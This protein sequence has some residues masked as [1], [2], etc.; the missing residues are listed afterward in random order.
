MIIHH[1]LG[2]P[3]NKLL[4]QIL[5]EAQAPP[6]TVALAG[7]LNCPLC[8]RFTRIEPARPATVTHAKKFNETL[9]IDMAYHDLPEVCQALV[10]HFIDEASWFHITDLVRE[11]VI[12]N[13]SKDQRSVLGNVNQITLLQ[14]HHNSW[15]R[16][17]GHSTCM[18]VDAD[19][20][21]NSESFKDYIGNHHTVLYP[22]AGEAHWQIG[23][24]ERHIQ[25]HKRTH[26]KLMLEEHFSPMSTQ[27]VLDSASTAKTL[28]GNMEVAHHSNGLPAAIADT[29]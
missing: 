7:N 25:T 14:C 5:R 8:R 9:C 16:Y 26:Q 22:C 18:R 28:M 2:H 24:V 12:N 19:G 1:N 11:G 29:G 3:S 4:Q 15:I 20:V 13:Q 17:F 21:F 6:A 27:E 23:L 10:I